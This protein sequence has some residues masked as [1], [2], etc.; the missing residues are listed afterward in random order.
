[1]ILLKTPSRMCVCVPFMEKSFPRLCQYALFREELW[2]LG[3][4]GG[5]RHSVERERG[6]CRKIG[7]AFT[8]LFFSGKGG[9]RENKK[10]PGREQ[11]PAR[12][13]TGLQKL[14][15]NLKAKVNNLPLPLLSTRDG[16]EK[17]SRGFLSVGKDVRLTDDRLDLGV[18][19]L[20]IRRRC[21]SLF[22]TQSKAVC[23]R[24]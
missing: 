7:S 22:A 18:L 6:S 19:A 11:E 13:Q 4:K 3:G 8:S 14:P 1:M 23:I 9:G 12:Q 16:G 24:T 20:H 15:K 21:L 5:G 17:A 2:T 10:A